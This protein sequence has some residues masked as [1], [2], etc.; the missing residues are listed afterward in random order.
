MLQFSLQVAAGPGIPPQI[1]VANLAE[2]LLGLSSERP[3]P[4][5]DLSVRRPEAGGRSLL[6]TAGP[7][8]AQTSIF[9]RIRSSTAVVNSVVP[10]PPPRSG[11][12][13]PDAIV[14]SA[15]S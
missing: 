9:V 1:R 11:V 15:A 10:A 8:E 7:S 13:V 5:A 2:P 4:P 6:Q 12:L 3:W 14:S